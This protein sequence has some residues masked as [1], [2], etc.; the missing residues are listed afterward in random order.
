MM[1]EA[2]NKCDELKA[3]LEKVDN[4]DNEDCRAYL[5]NNTSKTISELRGLINNKKREVPIEGR[6][7]RQKRNR[8]KRREML[9]SIK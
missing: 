2:I 5:L 4:Q 6:G 7:L 8:Q 3:E 9:K 1:E